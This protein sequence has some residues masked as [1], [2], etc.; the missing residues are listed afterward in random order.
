MAVDGDLVRK[1]AHDVSRPRKWD[2]YRDGDKVP[3]DKRISRN[4]IDQ[5]E[6]FYPGTAALFRSPMWRV[7]RGERIDRYEIDS[8][9]RTIPGANRLLFEREAREGEQLPR[10]RPFDNEVTGG[11][12]AMA[13]FHSLAATVLMCALS[14]EIASP[15]LREEALRLYAGLR[16]P[17][18][19]KP[20]F[21]P[22]FPELYSR[23]DAVCRHWVFLSNSQRM[24]VLIPSKGAMP[25]QSHRFTHD[26]AIL[27]IHLPIPGFD[28]E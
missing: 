8:G 10:M 22:F 9:L 7:L 27:R 16:I 18:S 3:D 14:E 6:E 12:L 21:K 5:A 17:L 19:E 4:A 2:Q 1:R 13:D 25:D 28:E 24:E 15:E 11:L 23:I 20:L 26:P